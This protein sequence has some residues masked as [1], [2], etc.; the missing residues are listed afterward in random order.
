MWKDPWGGVLSFIDLINNY[1]GTCWLLGS[2]LGMRGVAHSCL[3]CGRDRHESDSDKGES[4]VE[5][6]AC[7]VL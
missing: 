5:S 3:L 2:G 7:P 1:L 6:T 4:A